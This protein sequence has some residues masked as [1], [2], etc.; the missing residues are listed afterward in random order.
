MFANMPAISFLFLKQLTKSS[1][2]E[3]RIATMK[4]EQKSWEHQSETLK[5]Q[6]EAS[7]EK[8]CGQLLFHLYS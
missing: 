6:L 1:L 3:H 7:Q 8:V 5:S 4:Q 2:L